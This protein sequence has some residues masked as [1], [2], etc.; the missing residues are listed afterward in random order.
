MSLVRQISGAVNCFE[1][2]TFVLVFNLYLWIYGE[3]TGFF[4]SNV[5]LTNNYFFSIILIVRKLPGHIFNFVEHCKQPCSMRLDLIQMEFHFTEKV[6]KN[7]L[8]HY[9]LTFLY[10]LC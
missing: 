7:G 8:Y 3:S 2:L 10:A 5:L 1:K 4:S 9:I 6:E